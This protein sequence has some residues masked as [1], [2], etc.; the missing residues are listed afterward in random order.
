VSLSTIRR[1]FG[2]SEPASIYE[3]V[4]SHLRPDGPGLLDGGE[5]LP[6]D[7]FLEGDLRW[8]GAAVRAAESDPDDAVREDARKVLAG[9]SRWRSRSRFRPGR[10][11]Q[12]VPRYPVRSGPVAQ[13]VRA[14]DS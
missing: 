7:E 8:A 6:D 10:V 12:E 1:L 3:H 4:R 9:E 14:A 5:T 11:I 2:G 13:L